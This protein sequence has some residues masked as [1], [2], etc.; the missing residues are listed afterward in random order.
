MF[1]VNR[2]SLAD[3]LVLLQTA[4]ERK[5]T[6]PE[7]STILFEVG[8][9]NAKLTASDLNVTI[10]TEIEAEGKSWSGCIPM[11]AIHSLIELFNSDIVEFAE[12]GGRIEVKS[13][14]SKHAL[15]L[16]SADQYP[17]IDPVKVD[18][19][20]ID[21]SKFAEMLSLT[22]FAASTER[23]GRSSMEGIR[24]EINDGAL[25]A[26]ATN[27]KDLAW[28]KTS[29]K[30]DS[31]L[32]VVLPLRSLPAMLRLCANGGNLQFGAN[33]NRVFARSGKRV[34]TSSLMSLGYPNWQLVIP[35]VLKHRVEIDRSELLMGIKRATVSAREA[36][37]VR[38]PMNFTFSKSGLMIEA[39]N[40]DGE[41][42]E[43]VKA[44]CPTLNGSEMGIRVNAERFLTFLGK[45]EGAVI[46]E[47]NDNSSQIQ[48]TI[49]DD[50][51]YKYITM[52]LKW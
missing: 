24:I 27:G 49:A 47:F 9:G 8:E 2:Q 30:D 7:L 18:T 14:N 10:T 36:K 21:A 4:A 46:C 32:A 42:F 43:P 52:P 13:G 6:M 15:P 37:L 51:D 41:S 31:T 48:L 26:V 34:L 5:T 38:Y 50:P 3:E 19:V 16:M 12:K 39:V 28:A 22:S 33:E 35:G 1:T 44:T 17:V 20:T 11:K 25:C 23:D 29:V 40:E 45:T